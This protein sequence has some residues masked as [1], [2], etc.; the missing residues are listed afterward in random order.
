MSSPDG[1]GHA[2]NAA[3]N[4][5]SDHKRD[6]SYDTSGNNVINIKLLNFATAF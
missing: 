4:D 6:Q 3:G 5:C 1:T 2:V